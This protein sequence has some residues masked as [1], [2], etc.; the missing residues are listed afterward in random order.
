MEIPGLPP[1]PFTHWTL[2]LLYS[3]EYEYRRIS[4]HLSLKKLLNR[5]FCEKIKTSKIKNS[6]SSVW[7]FKHF[8]A[9][10]KLLT[11]GTTFKVPTRN[12]QIGTEGGGWIVKDQNIL[13]FYF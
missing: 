4:E 9:N 10:L 6:I 3:E 11:G 13:F 2:Q 8:D 1:T 5:V 7:N 12:V